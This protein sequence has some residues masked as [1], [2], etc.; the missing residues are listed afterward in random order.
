MITSHFLSVVFTYPLPNSILLML[1]FA[2]MPS[3]ILLTRIKQEDI[4]W[5]Q[6]T[7]VA[8]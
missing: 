7:W 1:T 3:Q 2:I 4:S 5:K 6:E 8:A